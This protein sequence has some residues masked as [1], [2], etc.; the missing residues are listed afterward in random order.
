M[1]RSI[2]GKVC[3]VCTLIIALYIPLT[4]TAATLLQLNFDTTIL[5]TW[6]PSPLDIDDDV[7]AALQISSSDFYMS[8]TDTQD[9]FGTPVS[10][11]WDIYQ[12]PNIWGWA[13]GPSWSQANPGFAIAVSVLNNYLLPAG[14]MDDIPG[15]ATTSMFPNLPSDGDVIDA[16]LISVFSNDLLTSSQE[17]S[18]NT[19]MLYDAADGVVTGQGVGG[20][21]A[22]KWLTD[23]IYGELFIFADNAYTEETIWEATGPIGASPVPIPAAA[24]LFGSGLLGLLGITRKRLT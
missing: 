16:I 13:T 8:G 15:Y 22:S 11:Q 1:I 19:V 2:L 3:R 7:Q 21:N 10:F 24:W 23:I 6:G 17:K 18:F 5:E 12:G 20:I 14:S 4:A 9:I